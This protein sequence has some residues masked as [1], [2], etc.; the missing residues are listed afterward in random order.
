MEFEEFKKIIGL[1]KED[2]ENTQAL[3]KLGIECYDMK[4]N[5]N[6]VITILLENYFT[7]EGEDYISWWLYEK[8]EKKIYDFKG[9][10]LNDLTKIEDLYDYVMELKNNPTKNTKIN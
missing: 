8:V 2:D 1:L 4:E 6:S 7:I 5:L 10:V 3:Y 9:N